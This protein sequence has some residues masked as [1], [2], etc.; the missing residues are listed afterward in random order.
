[1]EVCYNNTWGTVCRDGWGTVDATV[2]CK[3]LGYTASI[4]YYTYTYYGAGTGPIWLDDLYY[5]STGTESSLFDCTNGPIGSHNCDHSEDAG[6]R[7][8]GTHK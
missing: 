8:Y 5:C 4:S 2:A 7:C 1:M 3:Q 6:V